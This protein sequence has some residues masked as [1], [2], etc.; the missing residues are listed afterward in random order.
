MCVIGGT[1]NLEKVAALA[2]GHTWLQECCVQPNVNNI[3]NDDAHKAFDDAV[4][5]A[6]LVPCCNAVASVLSCA[7]LSKVLTSLGADV[8]KELHLYSPRFHAA[9]AD[10]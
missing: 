9:N 5:G 1:R 8:C 2:P 7:Q 10:V 4:K 3:N 6:A